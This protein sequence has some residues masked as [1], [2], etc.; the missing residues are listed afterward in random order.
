MHSEHKPGA[1]KGGADEDGTKDIASLERETQ[2]GSHGE[3]LTVQLTAREWSGEGVVGARNI[4]GL[5]RVSED[6]QLLPSIEER[7]V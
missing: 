6:P 2:K 5:T 1:R 4:E 3:G 7:F